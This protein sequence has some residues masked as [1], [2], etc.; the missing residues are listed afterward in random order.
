MRRALILPAIL[1]MLAG[2]S[3]I[4]A[5]EVADST[6]PVDVS[7]RC[8]LPADIYAVPGVE[9]NVYFDNIILHPHSELL[10]WD[11]DCNIGAQQDERWSCVPTDAQVGDHEL[12]IKVISP[13]MQILH[14]AQTTVHVIDPTAGSDRP[15]SMLCVGDSLTA[16]S[17]YTARLVQL[18]A[19]D[20]AVGVTLIGEYGPGGDTGNRQAQSMVVH[21]TQLYVGTG[22]EG[23][24]F[25]YD[26]STWTQINED[27]FGS[28]NNDGIRSLA[29]YEGKVYAGVYNPND[30]A[31]LYRYDG[32]TTSDWTQVTS[33]GFGNNFE[34]FRSLASYGGRLFIGGA[35]WNVPCQV[36]EYDGANFTRS[37]PGGMQYDSARCMTVFQNKLY[38]GTGNDSGSP[39]GGQLWEY[40]GTTWSQVNTN[41][42]GDTDNDAILSVAANLSTIFAGVSNNQSDG[43]KV[44][45]S[46]RTPTVTTEA[47]TDITDT[48][49]TGNG[50]ITD[51]GY[52]NPT[53]HGVCWNTS[54]APTTA[55]SFTDQGAA[56]ATG[57]FTSTM[58]GLAP[59]TTY[60]LRAYA[61]NTEGT[62]Y[63]QEVSF[64]TAAQVIP[65]IPALSEW[66]L[67]IFVLLMAGTA[68]DNLTI[69]LHGPWLN[70]VLTCSSRSRRAINWAHRDLNCLGPEC[71]HCFGT[72][73]QNSFRCIREMGIELKRRIWTK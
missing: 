72:A 28:S 49:A 73:V 24:V 5:Q 43:A 41:G 30:Y 65:G 26:G 23:R 32:P 8:I 62:A 66:G 46:V 11:V 4:S 56:T 47:V 27:G 45:A 71:L 58:I 48:A 39:G 20:A 25:T 29:V 21:D 22:W 3:C 13:D 70:S 67:I 14:Q 16:A 51:L 50:T 33:G 59:N 1:L 69:R 55:D 15:L 31:C 2:I 19:D 35:G 53:A 52:S 38:V 64:T 7:L 37:D 42:F 34:D 40:D 17:Q 61:T 9:M 18:F 10:L 68:N 54:G 6:P 57:P 12:T 63:G 60:Y 44:F 36:W